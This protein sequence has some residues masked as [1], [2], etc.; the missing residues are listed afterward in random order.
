MGANSIQ[1]LLICVLLACVS[2]LA[3]ALICALCL[4]LRF[5]NWDTIVCSHFAWSIIERNWRLFENREHQIGVG[6][7][8]RSC[9]HPDWSIQTEYYRVLS[10]WKCFFH[11]RQT[12]RW[13]WNILS[14]L[15]PFLYSETGKANMG[16]TSVW[17]RN[18]L[19]ARIWEKK[20]KIKELY[21][22]VQ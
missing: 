8:K 3:D 6:G 19:Y 2:A 22:Q 20:Q 4:I 13:L 16:K 1:S 14:P 17:Y 18:L 15:S 7:E 5:Q 9:Y 12:C 21:E 10:C 11:E